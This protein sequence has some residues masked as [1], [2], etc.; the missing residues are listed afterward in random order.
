MTDELDDGIDWTRLARYLSGEATAGER[1]EVEEWIDQDPA[2]QEEM[3]ALRRLWAQAGTLP[4]PGRIDEMWDALAREMQEPRMDSRADR[5]VRRRLGAAE[6]ARWARK[7]LGLRHAVAAMAASLLLGVVGVG[8]W[9]QVRSPGGDE[10]TIATVR[11]YATERGHT[12]RIQLADGTR[13]LLGPDSRLRVSSFE[14]GA[15]RELELVGEAV[16]EVEHDADR[17]FLVRA[18]HAVT[19]D[20]GTEFGVRAYPGDQ[21]VHVVVVEGRVALR[22]DGAPAHSGTILEPGQLGRLDAVGRVEVESG[23]NPSALLGWADGRVVFQQT[24][25]SEVA[26]ELE[27]WYDVDLQIGDSA[28]AASRITLDMPAGALYDVL[29]AVAVP[30]NLR[31]EKNRDSIRLYR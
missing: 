24:P 6:R 20:L 22:A 17:P 23:T 11:S 4:A 18:G 15:V 30:L 1:R 29:D 10:S 21:D 16:F 3:T 7:D 25:L 9:Y 26:A 2:R 19:E 27:R 31:Y 13:V 28:I 12:A 8:A 5:G 14:Q